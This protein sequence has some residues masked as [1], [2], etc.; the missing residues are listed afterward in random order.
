[1]ARRATQLI[2][3]AKAKASLGQH[4]ILG[5]TPA[6][7]KSIWPDSALSNSRVEVRDNRVMANCKAITPTIT[8]QD[9]VLT[10]R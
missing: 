9:H 3:K 10:L 4:T 8:M 2:T 1:M 7:R 6:A 5:A